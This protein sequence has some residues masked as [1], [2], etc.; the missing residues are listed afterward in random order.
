MNKRIKRG[1]FI[2]L[3]GIS[4]VFFGSSSEFLLKIDDAGFTY[5]GLF[6]PQYLQRASFLFKDAPQFGHSLLFIR[7]KF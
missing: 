1:Q 7:T 2:S 4:S 3:A 6:D 5:S